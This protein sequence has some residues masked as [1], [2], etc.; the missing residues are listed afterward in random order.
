MFGIKAS[1]RCFFLT[2]RAR[3]K[4]NGKAVRTQTQ[5]KSQTNRRN[6]A[7]IVELEASPSCVSDCKIVF[8]L[9]TIS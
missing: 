5:E 1:G 6:T 7:T 9:Y 4:A 3:G 2:H 8:F